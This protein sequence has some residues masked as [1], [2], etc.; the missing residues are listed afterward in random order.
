MTAYGRLFLIP[1]LL[2]VVPPQTVL[3]QRTLDI[4]RGL[5]HF[6][7]ETPNRT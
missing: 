3:P 4:A 6:V 7:V 2:G 1:S 5:T